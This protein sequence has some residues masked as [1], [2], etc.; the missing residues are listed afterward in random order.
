[1]LRGG[2]TGG[3]RLAQDR[4]HDVR[5]VVGLAGGRVVGEGGVADDLAVVGPVVL[6][7]RR[8]AR[9]L[10]EEAVAAAQA[11]EGAGRVESGE[12][13]VGVGRG[14]RRGGEVH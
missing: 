11:K 4:A 14:V 7:G 8:A 1:M 13:R 6:V 2:R 10:F 5:A 3:G 9:R 12:G